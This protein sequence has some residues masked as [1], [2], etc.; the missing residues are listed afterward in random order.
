MSGGLGAGSWLWSRRPRGSCA[1]CKGCVLPPPGNRIT[2][3]GLEGFLTTVQYQ[4]Q[5]PKA[6]SAPKGPVG[7]LWLSLEVSPSLSCATSV[8]P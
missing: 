2:E 3:V 1:G 5:F 8:P 4:V 6:K 7:L